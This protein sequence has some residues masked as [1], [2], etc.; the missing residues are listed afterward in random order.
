[1]NLAEIFPAGEQFTSE[2]TRHFVKAVTAR[3][4]TPDTSNNAGH[5]LRHRT[6]NFRPVGAAITQPTF[7]LETYDSI[8]VGKPK[9]WLVHDIL[10]R[11]EFSVWFGHPGASKSVIVG[12]LCCHVA[13][14]KDWFGRR[15]RQGAVVYVAAER[16][17]VVKRRFGAFK[18]VNKPSADKLPI[19]IVSGHIDLYQ[20]RGHVEQ[21]LADIEA[22]QKQRADELALVVIDTLN[23]TLGGGDENGSSEMGAFVSSVGRIQAATGAHVL[24]IHHP[25]KDGELRLRGHSALLGAVDTSVAVK[26]EKS[27]RSAVVQK[28][29]DGEEG[30]G[31]AYD[32][33]RIVLATHEQGETTAP[34][35]VPLDGGALAEPTKLVSGHRK[36]VLAS[37]RARA[38]DEGITREAWFEGYK[39]D[40]SAKEKVEPDT[41]RKR[42]SRHVPPLI[43][44]G[45]VVETDG[46]YRPAGGMTDRS[47]ERTNKLPKPD[48]PGQG[49]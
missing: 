24:A 42:F 23:R 26:H 3:P 48:A 44:D 15:V 34:I 47:D 18:H 2:L 19:L 35:V 29:N 20:G 37:L 41:L 39:A 7:K 11:G 13:W 10:G 49:L 27:Y 16:A 32:L 1:M 22:F 9:D 6:L 25:P 38:A 43:Y 36:G 46:I 17:A 33:K 14:G 30:I 5:L 21:L 8:D 4:P 28:Q 12:D 31:I 45:Q 40:A